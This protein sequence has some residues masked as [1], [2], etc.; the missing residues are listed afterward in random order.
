MRE[1]ENKQDGYGCAF[2]VLAFW[3][4]AVLALL[5]VFLL[6]AFAR[7]TPLPPEVGPFTPK[8]YVWMEGLLICWGVEPRIDIGG[9]TLVYLDYK[10]LQ[11]WECLEDRKNDLMRIKVLGYYDAKAKKF[12]VKSYRWLNDDGTETYPEQP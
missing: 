8:G 12:R 1:N 7:G 11:G 10:N 5:Y 6:C 9:R 3:A 4:G 2:N